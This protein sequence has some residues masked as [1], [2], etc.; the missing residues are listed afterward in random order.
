MSSETLAML[1]VT[2]SGEVLIASLV[3]A[4]RALRVDPISALRGE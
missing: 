4:F 1:F 2:G 3:P